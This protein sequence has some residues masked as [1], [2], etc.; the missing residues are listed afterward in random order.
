MMHTA[1][2]Y[3]NYWAALTGK[4]PSDI[5]VPEALE[6]MENPLPHDDYDD[7]NSPFI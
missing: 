2:S 7:Y 5:Y 4:N 6:E 1:E 3:Q